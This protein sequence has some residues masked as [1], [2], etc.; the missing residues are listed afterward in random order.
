MN[1]YI[2]EME[3]FSERN[4]PKVMRQ[5]VVLAKSSL[6]RFSEGRDRLARLQKVLAYE[7]SRSEYYGR[8]AGAILAT[9]TSVHLPG[10][11][12]RSVRWGLP[13]ETRQ[14]ETLMVGRMLG[15]QSA[16]DVSVVGVKVTEE[17]HYVANLTAVFPGGQRRTR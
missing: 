16:V 14:R 10:G 7:Y 9:P 13:E 8:A 17:T 15:H 3:P 1:R 11:R 5:D 6:F 4:K 12:I 2:L